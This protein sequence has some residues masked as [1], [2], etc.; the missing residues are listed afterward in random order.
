MVFNAV[1]GFL[2]GVYHQGGVVPTQLAI[3]SI[4]SSN[5]M[6]SPE[7]Q[8]PETSKVT[9]TVFWW[10]T[11]SPP[12]WLLGDNTTTAKPLDIDTRD[13]MGIAGPEMIQELDKTV[14]QCHANPNRNT[15]PSTVFIVAPNSA[16]FLDQYTTPTVSSKSQPDLNLLKLWSYPKHLNLDDLDFESDGVF[17][18]LS[19][20]IGRRGLSVWSVR[21]AGCP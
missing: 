9:A 4:V 11:Y 19:R 21:R 7:T 5:A 15:D 16:T 12:L 1:L 20:V 2:M 6:I 18:T 10:K 13:L 17:S 3:P 8:L 14:P